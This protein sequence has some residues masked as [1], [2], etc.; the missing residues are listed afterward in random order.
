V[1]E[2]RFDS[3]GAEFEELLR[4]AQLLL[5]RGLHLDA[6]GILHAE[7][8]RAI[9]SDDAGSSP[10]PASLAD[11]R[12]HQSQLATQWRRQQTPPMR[13][14]W[15]RLRRAVDAWTTKAI[16]L[17]VLAGLSLRYVWATSNKS[18]WP[19]QHPEGNWISRFYSNPSR[20]GFPL[21]RYDV[22]IN[23][24]FGVGAPA[25]SMSGD[26]FSAVWDT[27]LVVTKDTSVVLELTS[28]DASKLVLDAVPQIEIGPT[29][30]AR[31]S[32][33]LLRRGLRHLRVEFIENEGTAM[34][35]LNGLDPDG[36]NSYR[37]ERPVV[38]GNDVNCE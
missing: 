8:S 31:S 32:T 15:L 27:C 37:L 25:R 26:H 18:A 14:A 23:A 4:A 36:N 24:D 6:I 1:P 38:Q 2:S 9:A 10:T 16:M 34:V 5:D 28:D 13:G 30:G 7:I 11:A 33:V 19:R 35:R 21:V 29:A 22:G 17:V 20:E 3:E 12:R